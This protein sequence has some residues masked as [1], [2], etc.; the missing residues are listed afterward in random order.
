M[1]TLLTSFEAEELLAEIVD[2]WDS[3]I[4]KIPAGQTVDKP[5][6]VKMAET[7][8]RRLPSTG[9]CKRQQA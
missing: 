8:L 6:F 4:K 3:M 7:F 1:R 9:P 2:W 5:R